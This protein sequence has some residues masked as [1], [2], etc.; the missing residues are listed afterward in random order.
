MKQGTLYTIKELAEHVEVD[1]K[2]LLNWK[3]HYL[4]HLPASHE[5]NQLKYPAQSIVIFQF[6]KEAKEYGLNDD[7]IELWIDKYSNKSNLENIDFTTSLQNLI[8]ELRNEW[9]SLHNQW[10]QERKH[11]QDSLLSM[12]ENITWG[13]LKLLQKKCP[14][15]LTLEENPEIRTTLKGPV[16]SFFERIIYH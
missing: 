14:E 8:Q 5:G 7:V 9:S 2:T 1:W 13:E 11:Q 15:I 10:K 3:Y 4:F 6:I 16:S 12:M